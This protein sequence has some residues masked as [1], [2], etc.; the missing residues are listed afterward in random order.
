VSQSGKTIVLSYP[1]DASGNPTPDGG[2]STGWFV[3]NNGGIQAGAVT[4]AYVI[5]SQ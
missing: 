2:T 5:C 3:R 4:T 1:V